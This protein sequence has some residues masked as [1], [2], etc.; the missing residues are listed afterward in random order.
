MRADF[1]ALWSRARPHR[2]NPER[3]PCHPVPPCSP[4]G[5]VW[6]HRARVPLTSEPGAINQVLYFSVLNTVLVRDFHTLALRCS[7]WLTNSFRT[8]YLSKMKMFWN[9]TCTA[10]GPASQ[11]S[12]PAASRARAAKNQ[13]M[14]SF[15]CLQRSHL[16]VYITNERNRLLNV[17]WNRDCF[18]QSRCFRVC[19]SE[20]RTSQSRN[21]I[22]TLAWKTHIIF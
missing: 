6:W 14:S 18:L 7:V 2:V 4:A 22:L 5:D 3:G 19:Y 15:C 16:W 21:K 9:E 13:V 1:C 17:K 10:A 8:Y 11:R 20:K 12:V